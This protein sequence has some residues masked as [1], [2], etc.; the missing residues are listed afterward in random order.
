MYEPRFGHCVRLL[1]L[2]K[3]LFMLCAPK[4]QTCDRHYLL[5]C[6]HFR[7]QPL[8]LKPLR[9]AYIHKDSVSVDKFAA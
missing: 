1:L 5:C 7:W 2:K 8:E 3:Q 4:A 6:Q 9:F